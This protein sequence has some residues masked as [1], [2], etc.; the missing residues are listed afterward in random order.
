[1]PA[2]HGR[3]IGEYHDRKVHVSLRKYGFDRGAMLVDARRDG[4]AHLPYRAYHQIVVFL[5]ALP[6]GRLGV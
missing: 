4:F 6:L 5:N 2:R 1:M 3:G